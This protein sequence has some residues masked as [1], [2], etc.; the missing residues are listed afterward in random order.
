MVVIR[1]RPVTTSRLETRTSSSLKG[2]FATSTIPSGEL[3]DSSGEEV[4][5]DFFLLV[6][7]TPLQFE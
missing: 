5:G 1:T 7:V 6:T 3:S 2:K 4:P